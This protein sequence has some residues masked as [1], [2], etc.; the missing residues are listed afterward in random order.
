MLPQERA[1]HRAKVM[2]SMYPDAIDLIP[3][4]MPTPR[5]RSIQINA[6]VDADL[7]GESTTHRSQTGI[8]IYGC[9]A[10]LITYSKRQNTVEASTFGAEFVAMR[11]LVEMLIGLRYKLRMFGVPLDGPCNVFCDNEAVTK[12][13]MNAETT[14]KKKHISISYHQAREAVAGGILLIF[15]E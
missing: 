10:P 13:S 8:I 6:F 5:G 14:L 1:G 7:A 9:M 12:S 3:A 15:Y 2:R 4:N 11:V